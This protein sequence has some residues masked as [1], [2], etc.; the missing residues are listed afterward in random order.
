MRLAERNLV[1]QM[2]RNVPTEMLIDEVDP[3]EA[4]AEEA[5]MCARHE[6]EL[7]GLSRRHERDRVQ[8]SRSIEEI[9]GEMAGSDAPRLA[10]LRALLQRQVDQR[11]KKEWD[12]MRERHKIEMQVWDQ[13]RREKRVVKMDARMLKREAERM[14]VEH[15]TTVDA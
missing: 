15:K 2:V 6:A 11:L 5:A 7:E 14:L 13:T 3:E 12:D 1:H 8:E 4:Q 10:E 9:A